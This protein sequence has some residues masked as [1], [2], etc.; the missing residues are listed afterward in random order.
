MSEHGKKK[1][2]PIV[3]TCIMILYYV[4]YFGVLIVVLPN[5]FVKILLAII[6]LALGLTSIYVCVERLNEIDGGEE[7]DLSKY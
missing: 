1:I 3:I 4:I 5:A 7:D 2:A 6:P